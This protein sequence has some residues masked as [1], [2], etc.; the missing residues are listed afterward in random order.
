[1]KVYYSASENGFYIDMLNHEIPVDVTEITEATWNELLSAQAAGK[2]ITADSA[3][4]PIVTEQP[5]PSDEALINEAEAKKASLRA[6]ADTAIAPLQDAID[7]GIATD[8][9]S[10]M[11]NAWRRYRVLLNRLDTSSAAESEIDWP[12][13]PS[14]KSAL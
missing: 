10:A 5:A 14:E 11:L 4:L 8:D 9:E 3:G 12:E 2:L 6:T 13:A 1:M 7:L